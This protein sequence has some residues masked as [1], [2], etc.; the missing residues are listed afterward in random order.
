MN[1]PIK[2][3][4]ISAAILL[5][6]CILAEWWFEVGYFHP[7]FPACMMTGGHCIWW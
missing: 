3:E 4:L 1:W 2:R 6:A 7:A 5:A